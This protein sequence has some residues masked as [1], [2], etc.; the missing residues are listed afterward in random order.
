MSV[1]VHD[2]RGPSGEVCAMS[3]VPENPDILMF[4]S[5]SIHSEPRQCL[6]LVG[7]EE[8]SEDWIR[9]VSRQ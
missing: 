5:N 2:V 7:I 6:G 3:W 4:T 1:A 9:V 8:E